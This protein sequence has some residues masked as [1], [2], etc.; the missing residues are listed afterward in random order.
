MKKNL[1]LSLKKLPRVLKI[2]VNVTD[3]KM[4]KNLQSFS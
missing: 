1:K 2:A 4:A 3:I